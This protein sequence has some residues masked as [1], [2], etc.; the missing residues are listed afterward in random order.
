MIALQQV[1]SRCDTFRGGVVDPGFSRP[2]DSVAVI[3]HGAIGLESAQQAV[4]AN[5]TCKP[6]RHANVAVRDRIVL[7]NLSLVKAIA[8]RMHRGLP[9]HVELDD[10][11]HAGIL[12]L[13]DAASRFDPG[14]HVAF[15][16]YA[17]HR[18]RGA[19][20]DSLR[21]MDWASRDLRFRQKQLEKATRELSMELHRKPTEAEV[22]DRLGLDEEGWRQ[23]MMQLQPVAVVSADSP[24]TEQ[25]GQRQPECA[26]TPDMQPENIC[27]REQMRSMLDQAMTVLPDRYK[28]VITM[29]YTNEMTMKEIG[30]A[31]GINESRVSQI[32]KVALEKMNAA[33]RHAGVRSASAF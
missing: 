12:G 6:A 19:I 25:E 1:T 26:A 27:G 30:G 3:D 5:G 33:L 14:K 9:V 29:Y 22:A 21:Q 15:P 23:L 8:A 24:S 31:L 28:Q 13:I 4:E 11:T 18:I 2:Y 10:L 20:L 32:H 7:E 16:M 17:K